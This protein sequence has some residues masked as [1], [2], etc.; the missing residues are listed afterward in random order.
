MLTSQRELM[1]VKLIPPLR[2]KTFQ[3]NKI[4]EQ[5]WT[6]FPTTWMKSRVVTTKMSSKI[7]QYV[8]GLCNGVLP[9]IHTNWLQHILCWRNK[10]LQRTKHIFNVWKTMKETYNMHNLIIFNNKMAIINL[11]IMII[12][13][14][15]HL[16]LPRYILLISGAK[17]S[18]IK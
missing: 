18:A 2:P 16:F 14:I 11:K 13:H 17:E 3:T 15:F 7:S 6:P 10:G 1:D 8:L 4:S 5:L 12:F 9:W